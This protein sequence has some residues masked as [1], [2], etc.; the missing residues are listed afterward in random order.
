MKYFINSILQ[1]LG[2]RISRVPINEGLNVFEIQK[3]LLEDSGNA[4]TIFDVGAYKGDVTMNYKSL[5]PDSNIYSFEPYPDS[6]NILKKRTAMY[7][8]IHPVNK[9]LGSDKGRSVF[10]SNKSAPTN[11][12]LPPDGESRKFW[13]DTCPIKMDAIEVELDTIDNFV[14]KNYI[15]KIDILKIDTQ[16]SEFLVLKGAEESFR[17]GKIG[18]IYM[19]IITV[20]TYEGQKHLDEYLFQLRS[21]GFHMYNFY[22]FSFTHNGMIRQLDCIFTRS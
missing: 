4:L 3:V 9:A 12:I 7:Q 19:E 21:Y 18:L 10:Y 13:Y 22:N 16:G 20:P 11:S 5:F 1:K 17:Q 8:N 14:S 6:F 15:D 2:Y